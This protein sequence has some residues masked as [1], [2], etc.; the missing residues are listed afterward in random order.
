M[1]TFVSLLR[2]INVS[3]QKKIAMDDL[4]KL[5]ESLGFK[6]V[7][8]YIQSG[9]VVFQSSETDTSKLIQKIQA[10]IKKFFE[11]DVV[12]FITTPKDLRR[13]IADNPFGKQEDNKVAVLF[14]SGKPKD[15]P[16]DELEKA[17][18]KLEEF[19]IQGKEIFISCPG[20][21]GRSKLTT[22]LFEK[23]LK[24]S[25]TARNMNTVNKLLEIAESV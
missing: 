17:K 18:Q 23:K 9:N 7:Q 11:F 6:K 4:K 22:N 16:M 12:V 19:Q 15:V 20:G 1:K 10:K 3:G 21:F 13:I 25:G 5:Y 8:T 24:L 2:G 14:L